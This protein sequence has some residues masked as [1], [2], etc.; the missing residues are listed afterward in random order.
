[1]PKHNLFIVAPGR[2]SG[3]TST[4][5][6]GVRCR[7]PG[8]GQCLAGFVQV[9]ANSGSDQTAATTV[10]IDLIEA[11]ARQEFGLML[12]S[13]CPHLARV[14]RVRPK[15]LKVFQPRFARFRPPA[16]PDL[17]DLCRF[18]LDFGPSSPRVGQHRAISGEVGPILANIGQAS[19]V[20]PTPLKFRRDSRVT[21]NVL[22]IVRR[23]HMPRGIAQGPPGEITPR[24]CARTALSN[25]LPVLRKDRLV[26]LPP[27]IAQGPLGRSAPG[28][29][30]RPL[31]TLAAHPPSPPVAIPKPSPCHPRGL[32]LPSPSHHT[33][34]VRPTL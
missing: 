15:L 25:Y 18:R 30:P 16:K 5:W 8:A 10:D 33:A 11:I 31:V 21:P 19:V 26:K 1:M 24:S 2:E 23:P 9:W 27:V 32:H 4:N 13:G 7:S 14:W 28:I 34:H 29:A 6:C 22:Y 20:C 12:A 3:P 17:D